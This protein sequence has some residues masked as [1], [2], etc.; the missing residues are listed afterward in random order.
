MCKTKNLVTD[1]GDLYY[2]EAAMGSESWTPT[3]F[4]M[5][6]DPASADVAKADND[7]NSFATGT[8]Q[9]TDA[10]YP[11]TNDDDGDNTGAGTDIVSWRVSF[12]TSAANVNSLGEIAI[13][14]SLTGPTKALCHAVFSAPFNKT[15]D[16]TLKVFVNHTFTGA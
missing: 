14:D 10:G 7:V 13:C 15:S 11:K 6:T 9:L 1:N 16:D 12:G 2:A 3:G 5:G 8:N 4:R